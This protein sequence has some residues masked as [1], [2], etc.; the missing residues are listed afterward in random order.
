MKYILVTGGVISGIGKGVIASSVGTLL[1]ACGQHVT[2]IKIDPY[3]NVD[4]GTFSPYEHGEV[5]V[6]DDGGEV[7]LDLG[8]YERFLDATLHRSNNITTGKIYQQVIDKEREGHYL[9]KTVQVV[10]H[11]TDAIQDCVEK[12]AQMPVTKDGV[13]PEVCI[14]EL[15]GTIG[16]IEGMPF[17][18]AFRQFQFRVKKENFCCICVSL[19][20]EPKATGEQ[21]TK[22]TQ[23][24]VREIRGLGLSPDIVVCRSENPITELVRDKL[25]MYCHVAKE[26]VI[27][28]HDCSSIYRVPLMLEA[29]N[30]IEFFTE[31]LKLNIQTP[32][33][34]RLLQQWKELA[35][36]HDKVLTE[37]SI[38]LVGKYTRLKDAYTS[39]NKALQHAAIASG[40]RLNLKYI[41]STDLELSTKDSDPVKYH[42]SWQQLCSSHGLIVPGGFGARGIDGKVA[43]IKWARENKKP[44]LGICLGMQCAII[45]FAR[46]VLNLEGA[47][48]KETDPN[49]AHP[50]VIEMPEHNPGKMGGTMR[51]GRKLTQFVTQKSI[52]RQLYG[53][54]DH[55]AERH[56][57][58]Y[59]VN[60]TMI[61]DFES[62]GLK[63]VG[64]DSEGERMEIM[65]LDDHPYFV[66][67]Q[68]HPEYISRPLKPSPPYLGLILASCGKLQS[69]LAKNCRFP[70]EGWSDDDYFDET[71]EDSAIDVS[72]S[73][74]TE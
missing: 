39:V 41:A 18:E 21:K 55:V 23:Q 32:R 74:K 19:V 33:P 6:L 10:P 34:R 64:K 70:P 27:C 13:V 7:D 4:A 50:V 43:A 9:G 38:A 26:H 36:K 62:A 53:D 12:V 66:A 45:E 49:T 8:N 57:H 71:G 20:P 44:F 63:F 40:Y 5:F 24:C 25:S 28:I 3:L 65:E 68:Y 58:R 15:G 17:L 54:L 61:D 42:E 35:D 2:S 73:T 72:C 67:V 14:I 30:L 22:P 69:Y 11:I 1:K 52:T 56:R 16:D 47:N 29:Q 31:R 59:E 51:L 37:V 46:N 48:S 60:P